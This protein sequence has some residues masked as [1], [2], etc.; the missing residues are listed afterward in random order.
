MWDNCMALTFNNS[1]HTQ[2]LPH[3]RRAILGCTRGLADRK[4]PQ[5]F[6]SGKPHIS[7]HHLLSAVKELSRDVEGRR[8]C[9]RAVSQCV[10][11]KS[12]QFMRS[13]HITLKYVYK[14][15]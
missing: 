13:Y 15:S 7:Q 3:V 10:Q 5:S 1:A 11:A 2:D 8:G 4:K 6:P 12:G 14:C 9:S